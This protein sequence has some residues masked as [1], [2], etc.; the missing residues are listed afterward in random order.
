MHLQNV[1]K[2]L[3]LAQGIDHA[4]VFRNDPNGTSTW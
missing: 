2:W 1:V 4:L 3:E